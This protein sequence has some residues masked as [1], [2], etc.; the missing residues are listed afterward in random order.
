MTAL[1]DFRSVDR[2]RSVRPDSPGLPLDPSG[3]LTVDRDSLYFRL[4]R[5][6]STDP[7]RPS[8]RA[9]LVAAMRPW[10]FSSAHVDVCLGRLVRHGVVERLGQ[11]RYVRIWNELPDGVTGGAA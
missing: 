4:L 2:L 3:N 9:G 1:P 8:T 10:R 7:E 5:A 11:G 6:M